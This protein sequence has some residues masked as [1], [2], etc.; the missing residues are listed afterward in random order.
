MSV[1]RRFDPP[2]SNMCW[3]VWFF[4]EFLRVVG[5][6]H[7][8][9]K[10]E[11]RHAQRVVVHN[12][13]AVGLRVW[14]TQMLSRENLA[15][16]RVNWWFTVSDNIRRKH[17]SCC[18]SDV[19]EGWCWCV[20]FVVFLLQAHHGGFPLQNFRSVITN[21]SHVH[22]TRWVCQ[23]QTW[24]FDKHVKHQDPWRQT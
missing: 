22:L 17:K 5:E 23:V 4:R 1:W 10:R 20:L 7:V 9:P 11:H 2:V 19:C 18:I 15:D 13:W 8:D 24:C 12:K 14:P 3:N 6:N 16:T 21:L